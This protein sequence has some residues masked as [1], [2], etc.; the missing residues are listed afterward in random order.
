MMAEVPASTPPHEG[1]SASSGEPEASG[2]SSSGALGS[3]PPIPDS[4]LAPPTL[5]ASFLFGFRLAQHRLLGRRVALLGVLGLALSVSSAIIERRVGSAGAVDR[6]LLSTFRLVIPLVTFAIGAEASA[7]A[8]LSEAAWPVARFGAPHRDVVLGIV[9]A[10]AAASALLA[11]ISA[12]AVVLLAHSPAAPPLAHDALLSAWIA[13]VTALA[14]TGWFAVGA[15]FHKHGRGRF[16]PLLADFV[17]GGSVGLA[18]AIFPRGNA[19]NLLG[20]PAPLGLPQASSM[21]ILIA[22]G[23]ALSLLAALRS[24][25]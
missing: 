23:A 13:A 3:L 14:Y 7:R 2:S 24:K 8:R 15:T 18:G 5:R 19:T 12:A 11:A 20:G 21:A 9:A 16:W 1:R 4:P 22:S 17:L 25:P 6:A 10:A